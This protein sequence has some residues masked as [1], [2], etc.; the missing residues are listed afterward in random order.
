MILANG[1]RPIPEKYLDGAIVPFQLTFER[2]IWGGDHRDCKATRGPHWETTTRRATGNR[3]VWSE[4]KFRIRRLA[5]DGYVRR[6][7][8][9]PIGVAI[10]PQIFELPSNL[11]RTVHERLPASAQ[12]G[13][14][15]LRH[16]VMGISFSACDA[17]QITSTTATL[18]AAAS[19]LSILVLSLQDR[20][21]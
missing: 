1:L 20:N 5:A 13:V 19:C 7:E 18:V 9:H 12:Q 2:R 6:S 8:R 10:H 21:D 11:D 17:A 14:G 15:P 4:Q 16:W 3:L